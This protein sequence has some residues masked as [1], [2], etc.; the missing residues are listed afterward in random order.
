[1]SV[2]FILLALHCFAFEMHE[3]AAN[4]SHVRDSGRVFLTNLYYKF[5]DAKNGEKTLDTS[6]VIHAVQGKG[7]AY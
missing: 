7:M 5:V 2:F 4:R 1:M 6:E 3:V